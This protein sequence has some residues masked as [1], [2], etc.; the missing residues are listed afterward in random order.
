MDAW[1][2][3][4]PGGEGITAKATR[5]VCSMDVKKINVTR[6]ESDGEGGGRMGQIMRTSEPSGRT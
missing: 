4:L 1:K 2:R 5:M 3:S 6:A